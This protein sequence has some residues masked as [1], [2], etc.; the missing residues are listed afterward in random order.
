MD[1]ELVG[2]KQLYEA[3]IKARSSFPKILKN[4]ASG[5]FP[6]ENLPNIYDTILDILFENNL[7]IESKTGVIFHPQTGDPIPILHKRIVHSLSEKSLDWSIFPLLPN[8]IEN[9]NKDQIDGGSQTFHRRYQIKLILSL[10]GEN[11]DQDGE[12]GDY[13]NHS[14][15]GKSNTINEAQLGL[16]RR[17]IN[18]NSKLEEGIC[19]RYGIASLD[20]LHWKHMNGLVEALNKH[21]S[22]QGQQ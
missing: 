12:V 7:L 8:Y 10:C 20:Q 19:K 9:K 22:E 3:L 15:E 17:K 13:N 14:S 1:N 6:Y 21:L 2:K 16:L 4:V 5:R 18:N 11:D